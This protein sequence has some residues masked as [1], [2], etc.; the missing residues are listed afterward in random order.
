MSKCEA[1][2][3]QSIHMAINQFISMC[4]PEASL[5]CLDCA[6]CSAL[7]TDRTL[8]AEPFQRFQFFDVRQVFAGRGRLM[9]AAMGSPSPADQDESGFRRNCSLAL[10]RRS[11]FCSW[12]L[13]DNLLLPKLV[14]APR[15]FALLPASQICSPLGR[16]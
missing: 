11:A 14:S 8:R 4:I 15:P 2:L 7:K 13:I 6:A 5:G 16:S 1:P 12:F 10:A 9:A 3:Q